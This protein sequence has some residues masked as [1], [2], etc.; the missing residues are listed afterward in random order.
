M[1]DSEDLIAYLGDPHVCMYICM[2]VIC[3]RYEITT[4]VYTTYNMNEHLY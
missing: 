4:M 1:F 3:V 2:Y